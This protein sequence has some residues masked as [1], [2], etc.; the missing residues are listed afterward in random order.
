MT[1]LKGPALCC[2][3]RCTSR[4][5]NNAQTHVNLLV[6]GGDLL[7]ESVTAGNRCD[8]PLYRS[9]ALFVEVDAAGDE[10]ASNHAIAIMSEGEF[11][12]CKTPA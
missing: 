5:P 10:P 11:R 7:Y 6:P 1:C 3:G 2:H 9:G 4:L 12:K 8:G